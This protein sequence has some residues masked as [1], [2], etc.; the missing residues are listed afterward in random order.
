MYIVAIEIASDGFDKEI[1]QFAYRHVCCLLGTGGVVVGVGWY[2]ASAF[3]FILISSS[4]TLPPG[5]VCF[6]DWIDLDFWAE[7]LWV[8]SD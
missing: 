4:T 5:P 6:Q 7:V 2:V 8:T 1:S 3:I